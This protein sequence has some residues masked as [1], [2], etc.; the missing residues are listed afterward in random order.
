MI[1]L[2]E[3]IRFEVHKAQ[4]QLEELLLLHHEQ[5]REDLGVDFHMHRVSDDASES[6]CSWNFH[7]TRS[8]SILPRVHSPRLFRD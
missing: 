1:R 8:Q 4:D 6:R 5:R 3:F 7:S 2:R